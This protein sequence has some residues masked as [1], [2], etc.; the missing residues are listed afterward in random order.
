MKKLLLGSINSIKRLF[1]FVLHIC[2]LNKLNLLVQSVVSP[3]T[4]IALPTKSSD[5]LSEYVIIRTTKQQSNIIDLVKRLHHILAR[6]QDFSLKLR[7]YISLE[8]GY[9][10][11]THTEHVLSKFKSRFCKNLQ[12]FEQAKVQI[13]N[14][15]Q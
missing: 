7:S 10:N 11:M 8:S 4:E 5:K 1:I 9:D 12:S 13:N 3:K 2:R 6:S 15:Y 14:L